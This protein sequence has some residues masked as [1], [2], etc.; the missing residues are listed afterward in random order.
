MRDRIN[1]T[2]RRVASG[3]GL[4]CV[5]AYA[6]SSIAQVHLCPQ[7]PIRRGYAG[8][9][10]VRGCTDRAEAQYRR[11][12]GITDRSYARVLA[13]EINAGD[14]PRRRVCGI[15]LYRG[16][17]PNSS[18]VGKGGIRPYPFKVGTILACGVATTTNPKRKNP[19]LISD[20]TLGVHSEIKLDICDGRLRPPRGPSGPG[21]TRNDSGGLGQSSS[22]FVSH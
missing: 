10:K 12:C 20:H 19:I 18:H 15:A 5:S 9:S 3:A 4:R 6:G 2:S 7:K 13:G 17:C 8:C 22:L 14:P 11:V 21:T 1:R 16:T